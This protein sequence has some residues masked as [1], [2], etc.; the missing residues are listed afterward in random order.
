MQ[1]CKTID[2]TIFSVNREFGRLSDNMYNWGSLVRWRGAVAF[3]KDPVLFIWDAINLLTKANTGLDAQDST[4]K[5]IE[6]E[7]ILLELM[8]DLWRSSKAPIGA[9]QIS[10]ADRALD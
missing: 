4:R 1:N 6:A 9:N 2:T 10:Y 5:I 8:L 7:R 3:T